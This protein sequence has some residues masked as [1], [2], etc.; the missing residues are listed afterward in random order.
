MAVVNT[1]LSVPGIKGEFFNRFDQVTTYYQDL[2]TRIPSTTETEQYRFMGA[3][4][5]M[6]EWGSGRLVKQYNLESY[7]VQNME[8]EATVGFS[9]K[10]VED[11]QLAQIRIRVH[12]LAEVAATHK[13]YLLELLLA[14]GETAG[15]LAYDGQ[16]FFSETHES[17]QSGAQSNLL[18]ASAVDPDNPTEAEFRTAL[19][20]A[21]AHM[22][23]LKS[24][25][26]DAMRIPPDGFI[27][28][29]PPTMLF[30]A[31]QALDVALVGG[32]TDPIR[33]NVIQGAARVIALPGLTDASKWYLCKTNM[34]IRPFI[35]QD[36]VPLEFQ[37]LDVGSEHAFKTG[38][39][40]FGVRARY[41][42]AYGY[43]QYCMRTDFT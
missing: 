38:R 30:T 7:D 18:T 20:A 23:T 34:T 6:R 14:Y 43:W 41:R 12:E 15:Y 27:C 21:I 33:Q 4:P 36:R 17:G 22:M 25:R 32:S 24:D 19:T 8:Y 40:Q 35:F 3:A 10:E 37:A 11:D 42:I 28:V 26:G 9:Q 2:T 39:L 1:G 5:M 31:L 16:V 29:V 13:D